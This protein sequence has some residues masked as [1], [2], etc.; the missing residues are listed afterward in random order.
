MQINNILFTSVGRRV[1]L[2]Q[3]F[4]Q[5]AVKLGAD[6]CIYGADITDSAPALFYCDRTII[7]PRISS[8]EYIPALLQIC[9]KE[10]IDL[11][12]PTIDTDLL[13]LA[14]NRERF[15]SVGTR[16]LIS[17]PDR[18]AL[19]RDKRL[20]AKYFQSVGLESPTPVDDVAGYT[21]GFPAFIK[22]KDGSSSIFAYKVKNEQ[23]LAA[24]A[25]QVPEYIIQPFIDGTEYTVDIFCDFDGNPIYITP[26]IR[27][28][29]RA[30]EV[31][32]TQI[33]QDQQIISEM[34]RLIRDY[35]PCGPITVQLIRQRDTGINYYIEINPRFGG[36]APLSIKAGADSAEA[37]LRILDGEQ[38]G[39]FPN[40]ARDKAVYSR[41]DQSVC[42]EQL[43][44]LPIQAVIFDLDDTLYNEKEYVRSGYRCVADLL[45]QIPDA[46][47]KL[48]ASFQMGKPAIDSVLQEAGCFSAALKM[49]CIEVYRNHMPELQLRENILKLLLELRDR[50][51]KLGI[52]TDGRPEGQRNKLRALGL[53]N[54]VD[55]III[56]DELGGPQFRKPNDIAFRIM[57]GR[58]GVPYGAMVYI[59]DNRS[60][61]FQA[62]TML[63]MQWLYYYNEDGLYTTV[64]GDKQT[65]TDLSSLLE[66]VK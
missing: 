38:L 53:D 6:L 15:E 9:E 27:L 33:V 57:Q 59:G 2:V 47:E 18:I 12:I 35:K 24:Y 29:V 21:G 52:I 17:T 54:L 51:I 23:E 50:G 40:A 25:A 4:K 11:L 22:P 46:Y 26:R 16:V 48:W 13:I 14:Q 1:E 63:G 42:V 66:I 39:Y 8:S 31:L 43:S 36:G 55:E 65:I 5:A 32:K 30:G 61:D 37:V 19:C 49:Q 28:A 60:K 44:S 45:P 10:K 58:L 62:P 3:A 7:V 20:T 56:T 34:Q 41:F 64:P